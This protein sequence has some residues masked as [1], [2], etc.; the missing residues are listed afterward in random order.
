[1]CIPHACYQAT[2]IVLTSRNHFEPFYPSVVVALMALIITNVFGLVFSCVLDTLFVCTVRDKNEYKAA[3][4][5]D[6]LY[7]AYGFDPADRK[8][9]D[10][11]GG[12]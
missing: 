8:G 2:G 4:M 12:D 7:T 10:D 3:F 1:M 6:R 5:S 9:G 11:G